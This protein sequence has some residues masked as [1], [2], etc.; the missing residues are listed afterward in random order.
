M[1]NCQTWPDLR[2]RIHN[3]S[4]TFT[5][6]GVSCQQRYV[7]ILSRHMSINYGYS[8]GERITNYTHHTPHR[9]QNMTTTNYIS[10]WRHNLGNFV[11][12][13]C[14]RQSYRD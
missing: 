10:W 12:N 2:G 6:S 3:L 13:H 8:L 7:K 9:C 14:S 5:G 11:T 1:V 4:I